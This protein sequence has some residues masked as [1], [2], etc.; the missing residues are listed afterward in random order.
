MASLELLLDTAAISPC[1]KLPLSV[2]VSLVAS[3]GGCLR[4]FIVRS[5]LNEAICTLNAVQAVPCNETDAYLNFS[6]LMMSSLELF[7]CSGTVSIH[8]FQQRVI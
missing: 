7:C 3:F 5:R 8:T 1:S 2:Y 4:C 6:V